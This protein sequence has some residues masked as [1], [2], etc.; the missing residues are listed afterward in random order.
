MI[1]HILNN[2]I[3]IPSIT[4]NGIEILNYISK[5]LTSWGFHCRIFQSQYVF[6]LYAKLNKEGINLCFAGHVDVV[7][8]LGNWTYNPWKLTENQGKIYGRGTNDMKGPLAAAL[9]AI[10]DFINNDSNKKITLSVM[11]TTDEEIMT[12]NGMAFLINELKNQNEIIDFCILSESCSPER[13]GEY[14]KIGCK[15]SLNIDLIGKYYQHHVADIKENNLHSFLHA[16][17][18]LVSAK[19]DDGTD[20]FEPSRMQLTSIDVGNS[21][22]NIIP[23]L[24]T[25]KLNVRFN[26]LWTHQTLEKYIKDLLPNTIDVQ[27]QSFSYPFIGASTQYCYKLKKILT[28][29]LHTDINIGTFGGNS[30]AISIHT[31]TEVVEI[32]SPLAQA[33]IVDEYILK[34]DLSKL[35]NIYRAIMN[36]F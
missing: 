22:R 29:L 4:P 26:D 5:L 17:N 34:D 32:G 9:A 16:V 14:I 10:Y 15:G 30:D 21:I 33:H 6:N 1:F 2:L 27:F 12:N 8:P 31:L 24:I 28:D 18:N 19:L 36:N 7:P 11:L 3:E 25:A 35:F 20:Q 23:S 13:S